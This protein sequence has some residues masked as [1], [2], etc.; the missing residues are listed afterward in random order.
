MTTE[1]RLVYKDGKVEIFPIIG[2]MIQEEPIHIPRLVYYDLLT[3][4]QNNIKL[5]TEGDWK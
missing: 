5:K 1:F 3:V 2:E 4:I